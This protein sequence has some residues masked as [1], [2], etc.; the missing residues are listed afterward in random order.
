VQTEARQLQGQRRDSRSRQALAE[1]EELNFAVHRIINRSAEAP[2]LLWFLRLAMKYVP[3]RFVGDIAG[4][5][6]ASI[7]D[8]IEVLDALEARD[9]DLARQAMRDHVRHAEKLFVA[10]HDEAS[11]PA[12]NAP[13]TSP[14]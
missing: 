9:A 2:K 4:W 1:V 14:E 7:D 12:D 8:H 3:A 5:A 10:H 11:R 6:D 13:N